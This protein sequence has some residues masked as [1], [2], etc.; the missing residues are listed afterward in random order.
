MGGDGRVVGEKEW[1]RQNLD[2]ERRRRDAVEEEA[3]RAGREQEQR[4]HR[5]ELRQVKPTTY[6]ILSVPSGTLCTGGPDRGAAAAHRGGEAAPGAGAGEPPPVCH[7]LPCLQSF[8]QLSR[9]RGCARRCTADRSSSRPGPPPTSRRRWAELLFLPLCFVVTTWVFCKN[10]L[11]LVMSGSHSI[12]HQNIH[13]E[14]C[15]A[16]Y[17]KWMCDSPG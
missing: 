7:G 5:A 11:S 12:R 10:L 13:I 4:R 9:L 15:E 17:V 6:Y 14:Y 8:N 16:C 2:W 3:R 1:R